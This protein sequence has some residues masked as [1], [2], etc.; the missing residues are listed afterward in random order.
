[1]EPTAGPS[2]LSDPRQLARAIEGFPEEPPTQPAAEAP[3]A[4]PTTADLATQVAQLQGELAALRHAPPAPSPADIA[5]YAAQG[6]AAF[7]DQARRVK[8]QEDAQRV[9]FQP[10]Q[11]PS[12]EALLT[13]PAALRYAMAATADHAARSVYSALQPHL[14]QAQA[15]QQL[16]A[17][18]L[19]Q[20]LLNAEEQARTAAEAEGIDRATFDRLLPNVRQI[21]DSAPGTPESRFHMRINPDVV[22]TAAWMEARRQGG[23]VQIQPGAPPTSI[24]AT[25]AAPASRGG[26]AP[27]LP[28]TAL[29][30][31]MFGKPFSD[32]DRRWIAQNTARD[33]NEAAAL[34]PEIM[35]R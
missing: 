31:K 10:P 16:M 9:A 29:V 19:Q 3:P 32:S 30:E 12:D 25:Q 13:D 17:P 34:P 21:I 28:G 6:T 33:L 27:N 7:F 5:S 8:A 18:V 11:M 23:V 4:G 20:A 24:G 15:Q 1:M 26:R 22:R 2:L 14:A 35:A